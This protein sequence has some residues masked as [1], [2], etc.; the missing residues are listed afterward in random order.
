MKIRT[1]FISN[2]SSSSFIIALPKDNKC[3]HCG[4]SNETI[5]KLVMDL[6]G[7][8]SWESYVPNIYS[9][10]PL[11]YINMIDNEIE[12]LDKDISWALE[13]IS[14][15]EKISLN[16]DAVS[17]LNQWD[18]ITGKVK[19]RWCRESDEYSEM[20]DRDELKDRITWL[21]RDVERA[22]NNKN[23]LLSKKAK[24][25]AAVAN[26]QT[27]YVFDIDI[28]DSAHS[29]INSLIENG[30]VEVIEKVTS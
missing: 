17:L 9:G 16:K 24:I 3:E 21:G 23:K 10:D 8:K 29:L 19:T 15:L 4:H 13:Q 1:G 25:E 30:N 11:D 26:D 28:H 14:V 22:R 2:S 5:I 18:R 7:S 6:F 20:K 12:Q 27:I